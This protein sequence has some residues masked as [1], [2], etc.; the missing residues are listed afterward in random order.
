MVLWCWAG[1]SAPLLSQLRMSWRGYRN[2]IGLKGR[3]GINP[4]S[5]GGIGL[6]NGGLGWDG[7]GWDGLVV[8]LG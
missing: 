5:S 6:A 2:W 3:Q 4:L 8:G 7:V 1:L